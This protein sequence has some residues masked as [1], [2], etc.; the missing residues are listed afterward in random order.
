MAEQTPLG[1][2]EPRSAR[3][4]WHRLLG[5]ELE[6]A[7]TPV[8]I[9]VLTEVQVSSNPPK[10]DIVLLRRQG[11]E[12]TDEQR[13]FLPD[14]IRRSRASHILIE[15]KYGET[16]QEETFQQAV[17]YDYF[18]QQG[19]QLARQQVETFVLSAKTPQAATLQTF[20][21][22][23]TELAGV[24]RSKIMLVRHITLVLLNELVPE[25]HNAFVQCFASQR[26]IR[27]AAFQQLLADGYKTLSEV[28]WEFLTGL[29]NHLQI[30]E[31][32]MSKVKQEDVGLTPEMVMETGRQI[33]KALIA[34]LTPEERLEGLTPEARQALIARLAPEER[35]E[36]LTPEAR[37]ALFARLSIKERQAFMASLPAA[38][39]QALATSLPV[40]E[41][42]AFIASLPLEERLVGLSTDDLADLMEQIEA[43]LRAQNQ[44]KK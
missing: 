37:Q 26:R 44:A 32:T 31:G 39:R 24:Y 14:G 18:Y 28:L 41:R 8:G 34:R 15:F 23:Q 38:E 22:E 11:R 7:L 13:Q 36:G 19:Q 27:R 35:L 3:T 43:Y 6:L 20:G 30:K 4:L 5:K 16:I 1:A 29:Q 10:A 17:G 25:A 2:D 42:K 9:T 40:E 33:R 21:Y 12:W